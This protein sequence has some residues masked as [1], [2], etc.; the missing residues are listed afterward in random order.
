MSNH[1]NKK[2]AK[3]K[4]IMEASELQK[5]A[6]HTIFIYID[7]NI[8][9]KGKLYNSKPVIDLKQTFKL[10]KTVWNDM[11]LNSNRAQKVWAY[12][13]QTLE[14]IKGNPFVCKTQALNAIGISRNVINY[15]FYTNKKKK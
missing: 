6:R 9:F 14:L 10:V 1:V 11:K 5:R 8:A 13:A 2:Y 4:N 3:C 7:I 12:Y 15:L